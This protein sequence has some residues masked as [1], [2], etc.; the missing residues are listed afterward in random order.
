[1]KVQRYTWPIT[2]MRFCLTLFVTRYRTEMLAL[3]VRNVFWRLHFVCPWKCL[4]ECL[5]TTRGSWWNVKQDTFAIIEWSHLKVTDAYRLKLLK[6]IERD[7]PVHVIFWSWEIY[8]LPQANEL[9]WTVKTSNQ[10]DK[11]RYAIL[12]YKQMKKDAR[13]DK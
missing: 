4:W 13:N 2:L 7:N 12:T 9:S 6:L 3:Q 10:L 5:K 11:P 1:M 8:D